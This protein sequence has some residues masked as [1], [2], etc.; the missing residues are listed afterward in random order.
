M[1][2]AK[3]INRVMDRSGE[4]RPKLSA[5][6]LINPGFEHVAAG[7]TW[8]LPTPFFKTFRYAPGWFDYG[9]IEN[10]SIEAPGTQSYNRLR[11]SVAN[12]GVQIVQNQDDIKGLCQQILHATALRG[13]RV[14]ISGHNRVVTEDGN[15]KTGISV[16]M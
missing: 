14:R 4:A 10:G 2:I 3:T 1:S 13:R 12:N 9:R 16:W 6:F 15:S 5:N 11:S 7:E 8:L